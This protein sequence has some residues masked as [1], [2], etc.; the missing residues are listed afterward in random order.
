MGWNIQGKLYKVNDAEQVTP[1]FRKRELVVELEGD[2]RYPQLV[3]FQ[4]TGKR[5]EM[6]DGFREGDEIE[7]EFSL[8]GREWTAKNGDVKYFNS[9]EIWKLEKAGG[10]G[11]AYDPDE[12]PI[13]EE[14]P[15]FSDGED[16]PF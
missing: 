3:L 10:G 7:L 12:P 5:C 4:L 11:G 2:T 15:P 6:A 13:P 1:R 14:P 9:L 16:V 8:R